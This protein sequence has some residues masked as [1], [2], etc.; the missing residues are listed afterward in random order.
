MAAALKMVILQS[1]SDGSSASKDGGGGANHGLP[2]ESRSV[3]NEVEMPGKARAGTAD[4]IDPTTQF[5]L[6][7]V[8]API[9]DIIELMADI[10]E[11]NFILTEEL[12]GEITIISHK[13]VNRD[14]AYQAILSASNRPGSP[15]W[16]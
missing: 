13:P 3:N 1:D 5:E 9:R 16:R 14:A 15:S 6:D 10:T 2:G 7:F 8:N 12:K 4:P 11:K